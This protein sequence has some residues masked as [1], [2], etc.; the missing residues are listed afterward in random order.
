MGTH[1]SLRT[2]LGRRFVVH[3]ARLQRIQLLENLAH[4][5]FGLQQSAL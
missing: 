5:R 2:Q 1:H 4:S 3:A